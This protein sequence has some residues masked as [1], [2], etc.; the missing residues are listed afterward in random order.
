MNFLQQRFSDSSGWLNNL[1]QPNI[2]L[3]SVHKSKPRSTSADHSRRGM[4]VKS[5]KENVRGGSQFSNVRS[6]KL[7]EDSGNSSLDTYTTDS[8]NSSR[9]FDNLTDL[10]RSERHQY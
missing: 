1:Q 6:V 10:G 9:S 5:V 8:R 7:S 4:N 3:K 2:S